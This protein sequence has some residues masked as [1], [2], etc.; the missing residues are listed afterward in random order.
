MVVVLMFHRLS[1]FFA[2]MM[3]LYIHSLVLYVSVINVVVKSFAI[4]CAIVH[5]SLYNKPKCNSLIWKVSGSIT[6]LLTSMTYFVINVVIS[7]DGLS[8]PA[9]SCSALLV[10]VVVDVGADVDFCF[11]SEFLNYTIHLSFCIFFFLYILV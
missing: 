9:H 3:V 6:L 8:I 11:F 4:C 10:A 1:F 5:T 2:N 7:L